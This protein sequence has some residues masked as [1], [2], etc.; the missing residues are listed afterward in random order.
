MTGFKQAAHNPGVKHAK[1][2][3]E[4]YAGLVDAGARRS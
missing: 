4:R 3:R 2:F 1:R